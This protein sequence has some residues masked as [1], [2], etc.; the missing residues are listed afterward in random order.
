MSE[1]SRNEFRLQ[2]AY[3]STKVRDNKNG[4]QSI[5]KCHFVFRENLPATDNVNVKNVLSLT[6]KQTRHIARTINI[7][8]ETDNIDKVINMLVSAV[9]SNRSSAVVSSEFHKKGDKYIV[10]G[11]EMTYEQD[12]WNN[13][14]ESLC[15][16]KEVT[17]LVDERV[18]EFM[19]G[20][21]EDSDPFVK[22]GAKVAEPAL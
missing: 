16:S 6:E 15:L 17:R 18:A 21:W 1:I 4:T 20:N 13:K 22:A 9:G 12:S 10:D 2:Y 14:L 19:L 5:L 11:T 3:A 7:G 8:K